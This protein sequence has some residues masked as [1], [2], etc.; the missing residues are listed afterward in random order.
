MF[1]W[2]LSTAVDV[3]AMEDVKSG[4]QYFSSQI[5][6]VLIFYK[7]FSTNPTVIYLIKVNNRNTRKGWEIF[8]KLT[9]H[10]TVSIVDFERANF[11]L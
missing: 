3:K 7:C 2:V 1:D 8:S 10:S 5:D 4:K 11:S 9:R 6:Y